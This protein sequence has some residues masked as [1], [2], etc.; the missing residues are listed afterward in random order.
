MLPGTPQRHSA[1]IGLNLAHHAGPAL[2]RQHV[3]PLSGFYQRPLALPHCAGLFAAADQPLHLDLGCARGRFLMTMAQQ[4]PHWNHL[5][6]DIRRPLVAAAEQARE[7]TELTNL[8]FLFCNAN[9][10]LAGLLRQLPPGLLQLVT[11]QY[12]D[13]WFKARHRKRRMVQPALIESLATAMAKDM[14]LFIQSDILELAQEMVDQVAAAGG[15]RRTQ[16][17]WLVQ[18]PLPI[19][20]EREIHVLRQGLP[21]YRALFIRDDSSPADTSPQPGITGASEAGD[22]VPGRTA[23]ACEGSI[24][25]PEHGHVQPLTAA[26]TRWWAAMAARVSLQWSTVA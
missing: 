12:P 26:G 19:P 21:V 1:T 10:S 18:N 5:G 23:E 11:I 15:F 17:H 20:S 3:N 24:A 22:E 6:L 16:P 13:P 2:V 25:S 8:A 9:V 4:R 7:G 14:Q